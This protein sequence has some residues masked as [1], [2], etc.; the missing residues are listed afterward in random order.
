[1]AITGS[2]RELKDIDLDPS[3][4]GRCPGYLKEHRHRVCRC[5]QNQGSHQHSP[6]GAATDPAGWL[7]RIKA[8]NPLHT[9]RTSIGML[10]FRERNRH[11]EV[12]FL[13]EVI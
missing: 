9:S 5:E 10:V 7:M 2:N 4:K 8:T 11:G 6:L 3:L 12:S 13:A 1:M